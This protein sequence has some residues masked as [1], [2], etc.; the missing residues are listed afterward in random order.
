[1]QQA[2]WRQDLSSNWT[3]IP[4]TE[5]SELLQPADM[6]QVSI[7]VEGQLHKNWGDYAVT[8]EC[9]EQKCFSNTGRVNRSHVDITKERMQW[10]S[11]LSAVSNIQLLTAYINQAT[12]KRQICTI[13]VSNMKLVT[14]VV[15]FKKEGMTIGNYGIPNIDI[16]LQLIQELG[17]ARD[18]QIYIKLIYHP[19]SSKR[20]GRRNEPE[21]TRPVVLYN[22]VTAV[23]HEVHNTRLDSH[24]D[25]YLYPA[26]PIQI[27]V[28]QLPIHNNI[29]QKL[30]NAYNNQAIRTYIQIKYDWSGQTFG[31]VWWHIHGTALKTLKPSARQII[32]KFNFEQWATNI[33]EAQ[34]HRYRSRLCESCGLHDEDCDHVMQCTH[35]L[36]IQAR[37]EL[38]KAA[39]DYLLETDTPNGVRKCLMFGIISWYNKTEI[40]PLQQIV[41]NASLFL[42][43]AYEEQT[44]IGWNQ[45][46]RGRLAKSWELLLSQE[47]ETRNQ[48]RGPKKQKQFQ[49]AEIWGR[50]FIVVLWK[51]VISTWEVRNS[52]IQSIHTATGS[53]REHHLLIQAAEHECDQPGTIACQDLPWLAQATG[54][55][56][57][58]TTDAIKSWIQNIQIVRK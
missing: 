43:Q 10:L 37:N 42:R 16:I 29:N 27:F 34:I 5:L 52:T 11:I 6:I 3:S 55:F 13:Y 23:L 19:A 53:T 33:R 21:L 26:S 51:H 14:Q 32:S 18:N 41:P 45:I 4:K 1:M 30:S 44:M 17:I 38:T 39:N 54:N 2:Q 56:Q 9:N 8:M 22:I 35:I 40:I 24:E 49:S 48:R 36:R 25:V 7:S 31:T 46:I 57:T 50:K 15:K 58:M 28:Q 20:K 47:I 12:H